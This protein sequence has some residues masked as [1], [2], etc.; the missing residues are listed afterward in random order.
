MVWSAGLIAPGSWSAYLLTEEYSAPYKVKARTP[1]PFTI[2]SGKSQQYEVIEV[3]TPP[4]TPLPP[5]SR[6][7]ASP[8]ASP[9]S[10][11]TQAPTENAAKSLDTLWDAGIR[12]AG[13]MFE[14]VAKRDVRI[15][16]IDIHTPFSDQFGVRVYE[17]RGGMSGKENSSSLWIKVKQG[18]VRGAGDMNPTQIEG[19]S[20]VILAGQKMAFY[21]DTPSDVSRVR[22]SVV[23]VNTGNVY[24]ENSDIQLLVGT[25]NDPLFGEYYTERMWNGRIHYELV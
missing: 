18:I 21:I 20:S 15:T 11:P 12:N 4:P 1:T 5:T 9:T 6:P 24:K 3:R 17:S 23:N 10:K 25:G 7:T 13:V 22:Y 8:T 19:L 14:V 2:S 16:G